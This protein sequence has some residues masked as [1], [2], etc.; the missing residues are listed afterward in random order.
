VSLSDKWWVHLIVLIA[1]FIIGARALFRAFPEW[2]H[3]SERA[4]AFL[5]MFICF[6]VAIRALDSIVVFG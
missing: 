3:Y 2:K 1:F 4:G 5:L 6:W